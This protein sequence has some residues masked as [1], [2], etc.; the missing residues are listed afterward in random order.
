MLTFIARRVLILIPMMFVISIVCFVIV[1]LQPGDYASQFMSNPDMSKQQ[2]DSI[3]AEFGLDQPAPTRYL[4]WVGNIV[5]KLDF[6]YSFAYRRPV[7][8]LIGERMAWTIFIAVGAIIFQWALAIPLGIF[9]ATHPRTRRDYALTGVAFF[10]LSV[11]D[12]F[13]AIVLMFLMVQMGVTSVGGLFSGPFLD[14]PWSLEKVLDLISHLWL[15]MIVI[16]LSGVASLMR[17]MR[18]NFLDV[19][20]SPFI[21]SLRARGLPEKQ[22]RKHIFK[23]ALNPMVSIAGMQ[24]PEV[25]SGTIIA[26][27]V[28]SLPTMGPFFYDAL[29]NSDQF[30]V[31]AF[32][33]LIAFITQIGN[34]LSDIAL[35]ALDPRIR[36]Q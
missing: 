31:L 5:T 17:V 29:L 27:I 9:S 23:N 6:G 12:F 3:R 8:E 7:G 33:M 14:A 19:S 18:G 10:G 26:S 2:I 25:F 22:V 13:L 32:L 28:L 34:L 21:T 15:P 36:M 11:P 24:L 16:G 30:L 20:G 35:A 4:L 1:D